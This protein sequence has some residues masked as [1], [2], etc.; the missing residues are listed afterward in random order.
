MK[1]IILSVILICCLISE[2]LT[3]QKKNMQGAVVDTLKKMAA[4]VS[5]QE[6]DSLKLELNRRYASKLRDV[7]QNPESFSAA[8]DS[9]TTMGVLTSPDRKFRLYNWNIPLS[10]GS[11]R[12]F[13]FIQIITGKKAVRLVELTDR[14]DSIDDPERKVLDAGNWYGALYYKIIAEKSG[15]RDIYTLLGWDGYSFEKSRKLIEVLTFDNSGNP[16][17][18]ATVF[19]NFQKGRYTR[20]FFDYPAS[21]SFM[22]RYEVQIVTTGKKWN[23]SKRRYD[24][25]EEKRPLIIADHLVPVETSKGQPSLAS[26]DLFD[27]FFFQNGTWNFISGVDARNP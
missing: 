17:F 1:K 26:S 10:D 11:S 22:L 20:I 24:A 18:G 25:T 13:G 14:S 21:S 3:A 6:D 16:V 4:A 9:V 15:Q 2:S 7:L 8:F 23:A 12:Y 27:G 19:R 5:R